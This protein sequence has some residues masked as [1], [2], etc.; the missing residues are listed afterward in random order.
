MTRKLISETLKSG[1]IFQMKTF[2]CG[3][4]SSDNPVSHSVTTEVLRGSGVK[5]RALDL[6]CK[7]GGAT[8]G[9][10]QAGFHVTGVDIESQPRYV[11]DEFHQADALTFPLDGFDFIWASPP[12]Q[13][14][15]ALKTMY[16]AK[17]H[18][19]LIPATRKRLEAWSGALQPSSERVRVWVMENVVGAPLGMGIQLCG[20][21]FGLGVSNAELRRHRH[22]ESNVVLFGLPCQHG[23]SK[24]FQHEITSVIGVYGGHARNRTR[25]IGIYGEGARDS[26]RKFDKGQP[27]FDV[28]DARIAM[29]IEWMTIAELSQAIPPAYAKFIGEQAI[30]YLSSPSIQYPQSA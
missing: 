10:Q 7:A 25:T 20:T 30:Q 1:L 8:R 4:T 14:H 28:E 26:R 9:L 11:G 22:F 24:Y 12:C 13:A 19:D 2:R 23:T 21:S 18:A 17:P 29:G 3:N 15:T 16:N 6:Y 5:P 27:D